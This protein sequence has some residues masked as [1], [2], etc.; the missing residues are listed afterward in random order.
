MAADVLLYLSRGELIRNFIERTVESCREPV[1][2]LAHSLGGIACLDLAIM[3]RLSHVTRLVTVG[4]QG[5]LL[6]EL[7]V[8]TSL[9]AGKQPSDLP[10]WTNFYDHRDLLAYVGEALFPGRVCDVEIDNRSPFPGA[11]TGYF[12]NPQFYSLLAS[13]L[14]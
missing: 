14:P 1:I 10:P 6:Y 3:Q 2:L 7:D 8:L 12:D 9:P 5:P 4:S 11:H 13:L